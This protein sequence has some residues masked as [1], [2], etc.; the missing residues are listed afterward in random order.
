[1]FQTHLVLSIPQPYN[2]P[3]LQGALV[4]FGGK[5]YLET[6]TRMLDTLIATGVW[7]SL[8]GPPAE[9]VSRYMYYS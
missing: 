1:M 4:C 5:C 2:Q 6:K 8:L 3:F 7:V 9:L